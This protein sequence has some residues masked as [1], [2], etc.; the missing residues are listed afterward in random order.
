MHNT[1]MEEDN[2]SAALPTVNTFTTAIH[3]GGL[4]N[5]LPVVGTLMRRR[6]LELLGYTVFFVLGAI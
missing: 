5:W 2:T 3:E 6:H 1:K 4:L